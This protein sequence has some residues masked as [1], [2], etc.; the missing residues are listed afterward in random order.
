MGTGVLGKWDAR[1]MLLLSA[2]REV[3]S[4]ITQNESMGRG[5]REMEDKGR[6]GGSM[7]L[8]LRL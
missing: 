8:G 1:S 6:K 4:G 2:W 7:K 5:G 3:G